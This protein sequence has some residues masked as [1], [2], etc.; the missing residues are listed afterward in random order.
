MICFI[1][2]HNA[3]LA[4]S[5]QAIVTRMNQGEMYLI[6]K[7]LEPTDCQIAA[8]GHPSTSAILTNEVLFLLFCLSLNHICI[9]VL[10]FGP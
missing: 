10:G 3:E 7:N 5:E 8:P 1:C 6:Q 2:R 9:M 4:Y